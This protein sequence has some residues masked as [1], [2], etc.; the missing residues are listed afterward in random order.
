MED[1][2]KEA[3]KG[4][5]GLPTTTDLDSRLNVG[6]DDFTIDLETVLAMQNGTFGEKIDPRGTS[7]DSAGL[8]S[9]PQGP[10]FGESSGELMGLGLSETLPPFEM[11]EELYVPSHAHPL[12][13]I[14]LT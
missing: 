9:Q 6:M 2:L 14:C 12:Y 4:N 5:G 13:S 8:P 3:G 11:M 7:G 1:L 10:S